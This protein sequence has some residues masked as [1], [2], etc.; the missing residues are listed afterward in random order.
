MSNLTELGLSGNLFNGS[1]TSEIGDLENLEFLGLNHLSIMPEWRIPPEF[2][3]LK[4]LEYLV[5][6]NSN[7]IGGFPRLVMNLTHL[8]ELY[9]SGNK[10]SGDIQRD[11]FRL[12]NLLAVN[13]D[14]NSF[15]GDIP[16]PI[17]NLG[18]EFLDLSMNQL[19]GTIPVDFGKLV[20]LE[21]LYLD[22][23]DFPAKFQKVLE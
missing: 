5:I 8:E 19:T 6:G 21:Y 7:L 17:D 16:R 20:N 11:L 13:L 22:N 23:T 18:L 4:K 3:R 14:N 12:R 15:S 1:V 2:G 9:L 10:L